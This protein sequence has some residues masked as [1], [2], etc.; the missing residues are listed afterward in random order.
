[1]FSALKVIMFAKNISTNIFL[2]SYLNSQGE[3]K[4]TK[5]KQKAKT[6]KQKKPKNNF[7]YY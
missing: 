3:K 5:S 1:M 2:Q 6:N 7:A 4:E